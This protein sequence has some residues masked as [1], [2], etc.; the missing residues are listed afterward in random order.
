MI[1]GLLIVLI[2]VAA[3]A[4]MT[5]YS[6]K[7]ED[8]GI[9][10]GSDVSFLDNFSLSAY[11]PMLRLASQ[12]DRKFLNAAQSYGVDA[13][14]CGGDVAGK[15]MYPIISDGNGA[16][17]VEMDG[18]GQQDPAQDEEQSAPD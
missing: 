2:L 11:R 6:P 8:P 1:P 10:Y 3:V 17:T 12:M 14:I 13:L 5:R 4:L 15:Q 18:R 9:F 16:K 7:A